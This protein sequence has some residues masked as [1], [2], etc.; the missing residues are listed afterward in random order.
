MIEEGNT[1]KEV[2]PSAEVGAGVPPTVKEEADAAGP[3]VVVRAL[4]HR[5]YRLFLTGAFLSNIGSWL[6]GVAEGYLIYYITHSKAL[7]GTMAF[8]NTIPVLILGP[9]AGV[10]ADRLHRK[11]ILIASQIV[12]LC[13]TGTL[14]LLVI[15]L[16]VHGLKP[17]HLLTLAAISGVAAAFNGPAYQSLTVEFVGPEDLMN[18]VALNSMQ[19]NL[20]RI[21]GGLTGGFVYAWLGPAWCFGLNSLSFLAVIAALL[22]VRIRPPSARA[23]SVTVWRNFTSGMKFLAKE[24]DLLAI[25]GMAAAVT[26]FAIPY[27]TMLPAFAVD[28]LHGDSRMQSLLLTAIGVGALMA[29]YTQAMEQE[30]NG[31][32]L[33]MLVSMAVLSISL[34][35]FSLSSMLTLSL[36]ALVGSGAAMV[37]FMT[38]ANT[39]MQLLVPD[40]MRGRLM[41]V[42]VM[43]AFG[44]SP[45]GSLLMGLLAQR[46]GAPYALFTGAAICGILTAIVSVAFPKVRGISSR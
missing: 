45:I 23:R 13:T 26:V 15:T 3:W 33:R 16:G 28:V 30:G 46:V 42:F 8:F 43:A 40:H 31:M 6:Q 39:A 25:V 41:G 2:E 1:A 32:G 35:I 12:F 27:F 34:M 14:A 10:A 4:R 11:T 38:T 7:L 37:G 36:V 22:M 24:P 44:L 5:D 20:S 21:V 19:F 9:L 18:A 29:A 17:W